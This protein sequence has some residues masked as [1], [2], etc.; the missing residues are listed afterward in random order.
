M[1][2]RLAEALALAGVKNA[3]G[4]T[5][6]GPTWKLITQL[7]GH[8]VRYFPSGH[9]G[10]GAI[11]AGAAGK[12]GSRLA[13]SLSI[14]GPGLANMASGIAFNHFENLPALSI[15]EAYGGNDPVSRMH[16]RMDQK[17]FLRPLVKGSFSLDEAAQDFQLVTQL[18]R[19]EVQGPVHVDLAQTQG[20]SE[21]ITSLQN[22]SDEEFAT[23]RKLID[24]A[25]RP[26]VI[27][28]SWASRQNWAAGLKDLQVPV[29]TTAAAKG[30]VDESG[31][32]SAG[33]FTGAGQKTAPESSIFRQ[34]D[35]VIA[36]GLR[37]LEVLTVRPFAC[38]LLLVDAVAEPVTNGLEATLHLRDNDGAA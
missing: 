28:G 7:E 13:I 29:F 22:S 26:I 25:Q 12:A 6:S 20:F 36:F 27:A 24:S 31:P 38:K 21:R 33:V 34:A 18:A 11:M 16:K 1:I 15:S 23:A 8:G 37:N 4:V 9:E 14:K 10:A 5:G 32:F 17:A 3:F 35:L 30:I 2:E 19:A